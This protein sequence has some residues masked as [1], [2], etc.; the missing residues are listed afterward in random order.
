M[1]ARRA[2]TVATATDWEKR[3]E[4]AC[5]ARPTLTA[6]TPGSDAMA[7]RRAVACSTSGSAHDAP[8]GERYSPAGIIPVWEATRPLSSIVWN[9]SD[10]GVAVTTVEVPHDIALAT[11]PSPP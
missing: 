2:R 5:R 11:A 4:A 9:S 7:R 1:S 3:R 6:V 8:D 10:A